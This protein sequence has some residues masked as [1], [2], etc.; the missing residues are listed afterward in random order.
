LFFNCRRSMDSDDEFSVF[1]MDAST[2]ANVIEDEGPTDVEILQQAEVAV[3]ETNATAIENLLTQNS[4]LQN[5]LNMALL[6]CKEN[7]ADV[8]RLDEVKK[9]LQRLNTADSRVNCGPSAHSCSWISHALEEIF[10]SENNSLSIIYTTLFAGIAFLNLYVQLNYTGPAIEDEKLSDLYELCRVLL[11]K[12]DSE[13][14]KSALHTNAVIS[15]QVDGESPFSIC[16]H[17]YY[18]ELS[19]CLLH[20]LGMQSYVNWSHSESINNISKFTPMD[21]YTRQPRTLNGF[22]RPI[23]ISITVATR[24]LV[25]SSWWCARAL[26]A[27]QRLLITKEASNTLWTE[28]QYCFSYVL[29]NFHSTNCSNPYLPARGQLEWGLAQHFFEVKNKGRADYSRA[30][31]TTGLQ[32]QLSGSMGKRTKFQVKEVAQMVLFAKSRVENEQKSSES[33][34]ATAQTT[35]VDFGGL[36]KDEDDGEPS[37]ELTPEEKLIAD[38]EA[39]YRTITRDQADPDNILLENIAFTDAIENSNLQVIDQ[40]ILLALCLDVKNSNANDG[41]TREQM[42]PY[43]TRVLDNP[44]NWMVYSTGLLE[45]AWLE[46]ETMRSRERA[47][48]QIQALVD[49]HTTRLT[50]TQTSLKMIEDAAP[51]HERME[52]IYSLVFP[53]RYALKRDLAERYL[54]LGVYASALEI[55]KELEMWDEIVQCHQLLDQ[56][57]RAEALIRQRLEVAP[58]PFMWC[59]LG[60]I[61]E[62]IAHY[63]T[64]WNLSQGR[65]ARAKRSW[66][67]KLYEKGDTNGAIT[68]L[69]DATKV[70]PMFTQAWFF[71]GSLAMRTNQWTIAF[72]AF[73]HVVQLSPDDGEAWGNIGSIHLRLKNYGQAFSAFQEAL[74]QKRSMWQMWENFLLC[75]MEV[76]RY[77]DAMYA[78]HQL[79]DLREKHKR[80]I[81]HEI[82][83]WL[84]QAVVYPETTEKTD[85]EDQ[86]ATDA[87][88][89]N[90]SSMAVLDDDDDDTILTITPPVSEFNYKKQL[91]K[92]LGRIT[93][94]VTNNPKLWQVYAHYHDGCGHPQKALECRLKEC[95]ALQKAGW[96]TNEQDVVL[97]CKAALRL[98]NDYIKE[99]SKTSLHDCRMYLRSLLKKAQLDYARLP[100]VKQ[101][102][103]KKSHKAKKAGVSTAPSSPVKKAVGKS[104]SYPTT[105][106][107]KATSSSPLA[108]DI[109]DE[110]YADTT[111]K[112]VAPRIERRLS[113]R[114]DAHELDYQNIIHALNM[115]PQI[116]AAAKSLERKLNANSVGHLLEKRRSMNELADQGL[117]ADCTKIAPTLHAKSDQLKRQLTAAK[118]NK[119]IT[120]RP[121]QKELAEQGVLDDAHVAPC[122]IATAKKLERTMIENQVGHLLETRPDIHNVVSQHICPEP[123]QV[124]NSIQSAMHSLD[125]HLKADQLSRKLRSRRSFEQ[126]FVGAKKRSNSKEENAARRARYTLALKAASRIAADKL[127]SPTEKGRLKDLILSDDRRV[128]NALHNYEADNDVEEMLDSLYRIAKDKIRV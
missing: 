51:A 71:L 113:S 90:V 76:Q 70:Q 36:K 44:N 122:L 88:K 89:V 21:L 34:A 75:A 46:C 115:A 6:L 105:P 59:S 52:Y 5:I 87:S 68:H 123:P 66:A 10:T 96:E 95:R 94:I 50:I 42:M 37:D 15:L 24:S 16:E 107:A 39:A 25:T 29:Q 12:K 20:F 69:I 119:Q 106:I 114:P 40:T 92:L 18:L 17:P 55:F 41:L 74:K 35:H 4:S 97:L 3:I 100:E 103:T 47:V 27:H 33:A 31:Q 118:L 2:M 64:S 7:Y 93:S 109:P 43:L 78:I 28:T 82:L 126:L 86:E 77:G 125:R 19:R 67:R 120:R 9:L 81:D 60:D 63:E 8:L 57:K 101:L 111:V 54:G 124:A 32:V 99:G 61:T 22:Q 62:D 11:P 85:E 49:Q 79:L 23:A 48:L 116:Q 30:L 14:S 84:V 104:S 73:T 102:M 117:V 83:A 56:P 38:G 80:P 128:M 91:A 98:A 112:G 127:I 26:I 1:S 108:S 110:V 53:P 65:F 13:V 72:E 58:T 45:R 121:S